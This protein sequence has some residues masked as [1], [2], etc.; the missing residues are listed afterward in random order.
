MAGA[1]RLFGFPLA[2]TFIWMGASDMELQQAI[3]V[4]KAAGYKVSAPRAKAKATRPALNA[5]GRPFSPLYDP[6]YRMKY[7]TPKAPQFI[8]T[9][10]RSGA[11]DVYYAQ[12]A[13][14]PRHIAAQSNPATRTKCSCKSCKA[15]AAAEAS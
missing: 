1:G 6:H 12:L 14:T 4:V 11:W 9:A 3:S 13:Q 5:I 8:G 7:K 15:L 10:G 2:T